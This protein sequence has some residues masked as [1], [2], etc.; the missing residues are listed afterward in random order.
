MWPIGS[1]DLYPEIDRDLL[2]TGIFLHDIGKIDELSYDRAFAYTDEGQLVGHLVM[3]VEMLRDKVE[4]TQ[5]LTGESFPSELLLRLKH[6]IVSHHGAHE[7]GSPK[8]PMTLEAD[9]APLPRQ[10][11]RQDPCLQPRDPRRPQPRLE[12]DPLP[13][14]PGTPALQ[15]G[16]RRGGQRIRRGRRLKAGPSLS[17]CLVV[18]TVRF[19]YRGKRPCAALA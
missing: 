9:R 14:K 12:L 11:R 18:P 13:A 15:G 5:E 4:R 2:L 19:T 3:G 8:L 7:F 16:A 10:S 17:K 6:M 1:L